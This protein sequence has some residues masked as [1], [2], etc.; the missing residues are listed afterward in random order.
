MSLKNINLKIEACT[1][2]GIV[3]MEVAKLHWLVFWSIRTFRRKLGGWNIVKETNLKSWQ[4]S[5]G[6]ITQQI[7]LEQYY[8]VN[9]ALVR[10]RKILT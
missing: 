1:K 8:S 6:Y 3:N 5:I 10:I 7:Y 2:V 4:Q 9:I